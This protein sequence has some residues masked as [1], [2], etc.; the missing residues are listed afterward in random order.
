MHVIGTD[1]NM[2]DA[3]MH[4]IGTNRN[5][6]DTDANVIGTGRNM[7]TIVCL[8]LALIYIFQTLI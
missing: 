8:L 3:N 7:A 1:R 6:T 4:A 2:T 5:I